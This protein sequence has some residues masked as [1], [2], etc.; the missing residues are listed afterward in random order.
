MAGTDR[1]FRLGQN[2]REMPAGATYHLKKRNKTRV[3][4]S[5][6]IVVIASNSQ[7]S[8]AGLLSMPVDA[9]ILGVIGIAFSA[10]AI[11]KM[12]ASDLNN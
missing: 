2:H 7:G 6:V 10:M 11:H 4:S 12:T 8:H 9:I 5:I 3:V 1:I